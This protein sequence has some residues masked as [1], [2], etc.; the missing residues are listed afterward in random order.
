MRIGYLLDTNA[1][2]YGQKVPDPRNASE[3]LHALVEECILAEQAGYHSIC[4]P[5]RHN[6]SESYFGSPLNLL[7]ILAR[8][9]QRV[10]IGAYCLVNTLYH[11]MHV[12]EQCAIIDNLSR[13]RLFM[14]WGRGYHEGY[15]GQFGI[16]RE[17]LLGRFLENVRIIAQALASKGERISV[18][19]DFYSVQDGLLTPN[20]YQQPR[21]PFWGGGQFTPSIKRSADYAES[22]TCDD[23]PILRDVW[24]SQVGGYREAAVAKGKEP[25]IVLMRNGWVA[26]SFEDAAESFGTHYVSEMRFYCAAGILSHHPEFSSPEKITPKRAREHIVIGSPAQCRE[27]LEQYYEELGVQYFTIRHRMVTGPSFEAAREQILRF[28]EEVVQPLHKKYPPIDHPAI[29]RVC[30]W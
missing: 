29:P 10:A 15:W 20:C 5:D 30:R 4:V 26:D 18:D 12:A 7:M 1:G 25:F 16:P 13:G 2:N 9:T 28:G 6:R 24:E 11:P 19:G 23:F 3:T 27:R 8:E 14:T 22:W 17:R 21:F